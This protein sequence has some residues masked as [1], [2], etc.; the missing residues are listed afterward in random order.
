[1]GNFLAPI[2]ASHLDQINLG[3]EQMIWNIYETFK[4]SIQ[5]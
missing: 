2:M 1:M 5:N 3:R 4:Q